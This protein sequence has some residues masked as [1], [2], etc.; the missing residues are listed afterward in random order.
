MFFI[1][2]FTSFKEFRLWINYFINIR[3]YSANYVVLVL[4]REIA[5]IL[6]QIGI[7]LDGII[8]AYKT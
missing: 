8:L 7:Y 5:Q 6:L 3:W 2:F 4:L 1:H